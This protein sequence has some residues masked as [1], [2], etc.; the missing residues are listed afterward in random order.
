ML[1]CIGV[2]NVFDAWM[3]AKSISRVVIG[4][5]TEQVFSF[6]LRF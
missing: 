1:F 5:F 3:Q 6:I 4:I 2:L